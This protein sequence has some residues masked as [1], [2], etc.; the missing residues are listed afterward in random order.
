MIGLIR[1]LIE[2][3]NE[4]AVVAAAVLFLLWMLTPE[5]PD[6]E[7]PEEYEAVLYRRVE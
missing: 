2:H 1:Q 3:Q 6:V 7:E 4:V 5:Q